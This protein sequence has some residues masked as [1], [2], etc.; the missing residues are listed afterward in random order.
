MA[1]KDLEVDT[2]AGADTNGG[3]TAG[4][5]LASG[6]GASTDGTSTVDLSADTPDL[7]AVVAGG[8]IAI[9]SRTDGIRSTNIYEILTINDGADTITVTPSPGTASG[10]TW[11]IGG[12]WKTLAKQALVV[13]PG[14]K[15]FVK[16]SANYNE[17]FVISI[18]GT[19]IAPIVLEGYTTT[20]GD[21]G[22]V[23]IDGQATRASGVTQ[24]LGN[25]NLFHTL[26]NFR[27]T[28]H[29]SHGV[30]L[31][32][33]G[34]QVN[35]FNVRSDNNAGNGLLGDNN[36]R[37]IDCE[38]DN[39]ALI[40]VDADTGTT[41]IGCSVH[42]NT[43][44]GAVL[45]LDMVAFCE[46]YGN[47]GVQ[48]VVEQGESHIINSTI[49]GVDKTNIGLSFIG[50]GINSISTVINNIITRCSVGISVVDDNGDQQLAKTNNLFDNTTD[51]SANWPSTAQE[52]D[53]TTDPDFVNQ[54]ADDYQLNSTSDARGAGYDVGQPVNA[55]SFMDIGAHQSED[56]VGGMTAL[57]MLAGRAG[58]K[59]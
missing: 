5:A 6:A 14:D 4:S 27:F 28:D 9:A 26:K 23:T 21:D 37:M 3:S 15:V 45:K 35:L 25:V 19:A 42:N 43:G 2:S 49:D 39:N 46:F 17:N 12:A 51:Y 7:S 41:M 53:I 58:G 13:E 16:A 56:V 33:T 10:Q 36:I 29:T 31:G 48:L 24:S 18:V 40:G 34:D 11:A 52:T 8:A 20:R 30:N 59:Q 1:L 47:G 54:A 44:A 50:T 32:S 22:R 38:F 57:G 55:A